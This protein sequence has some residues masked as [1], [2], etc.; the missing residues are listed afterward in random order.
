VKAL[1]IFIVAL[2]TIQLAYSQGVS[3]IKLLEYRESSCDRSSDPTRII[4]RIISSKTKFDT[5]EIEIGFAGGCCGKV[6]PIVEFKNDTLYFNFKPEDD[7]ECF[8]ACCFSFYYKIKGINKPITRAK[9]FNKEIA[10][11]SEKYRTFPVSFEIIEKDTFN[12]T[13]KYGQKQGVWYLLGNGVLS[14]SFRRYKNDRIE[15]YGHLY[16]NYKIEK[17]KS[18]TTNHYREYYKSGKLKKECKPEIGCRY[19]KENGKELTG[20][21]V[22]SY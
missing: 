20:K 18:N 10:L 6:S 16:E 22:F 9:L 7:E 14:I 11:S 1:L 2:S 5:L 12:L 21:S 17:E 4:P 13:D 19:W 8:C 3:G 15:G